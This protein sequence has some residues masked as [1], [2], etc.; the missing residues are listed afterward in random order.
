[1]E[2]RYDVHLAQKIREYYEAHPMEQAALID[3]SKKLTG[4][5][6]DGK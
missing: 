6:K 1:M 5:E 2:A 4:D 3:R